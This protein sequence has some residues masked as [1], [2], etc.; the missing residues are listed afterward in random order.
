MND[1]FQKRQ[2]GGTQQLTE[3]NLKDLKGNH[4]VYGIDK[5]NYQTTN[6]DSLNWK[7]PE[8]TMY[9]AKC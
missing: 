3:Q 9:N 1:A 4:V 6:K 5:E 2:G 8:K 7:Q